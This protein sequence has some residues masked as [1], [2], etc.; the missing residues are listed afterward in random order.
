M[1][2]PPSTT[3]PP[4]VDEAPPSPPQ[5]K[6]IAKEFFNYY[7]GAGCLLG[8]GAGI[9]AAT[10]NR[11]VEEESTVLLAAA[12]A[13]I[14]LL[15]VVVTAMT[16]V[17]AFIEGKFGL[18]ISGLGTRRFFRPFVVVAVVSAIDAVVCFAGALD[19]GGG[20]PSTRVGR[21]AGVAS[22]GVGPVWTRDALFGIAAWLLV[23]AIAG[24][25]KLVRKLVTYAEQRARFFAAI[26]PDPDPDST[27]PGAGAK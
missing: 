20:D 2:D 14:G 5:D 15:A 3:P 1:P 24:V 11:I 18:M 6:G 7:H 22:A 16:L 26:P 17:I 10:T 21:S 12:G 4:T 8:I 13:A 19:S 9:W 23:W 25:I 27:E